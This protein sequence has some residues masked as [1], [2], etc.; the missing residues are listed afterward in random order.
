MSSVYTL[1]PE[2][3]QHLLTENIYGIIDSKI[4][5]I[6]F[7]LNK[8]IQ[9]EETKNNHYPNLAGSQ[10]PSASTR[11]LSSEP[12]NNIE[13]L[14]QIE[15]ST[16]V[17]NRLLLMRVHLNALNAKLIFE[18]LGNNSYLNYS[19]EELKKLIA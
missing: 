13:I 10:R 18:L 7:K 1:N 19:S 15:E 6:K 11:G 12:I 3:N 17:I 4:Q 2:L 16:K 5:Y 9:P 8:V 14:D